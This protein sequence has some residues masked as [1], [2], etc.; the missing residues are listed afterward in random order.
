MDERG[1]LPDQAAP[2]QDS[3][4]PT[5]R[6]ALGSTLLGGLLV[7][8][9]L[10]AR[11]IFSGGETRP[12]TD[13]L[14]ASATRQAT[15]VVAGNQATV[16]ATSP[17]AAGR[18]PGS[19]S[20]T[21]SGQAGDRLRVARTDGQGVVLRASPREDDWTPRGFMDGDWVTVLERRGADW[22]RVRG[23]NGED[24]WVPARYLGP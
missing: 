8:A 11:V 23:D 12:S 7:A 21:P 13:V 5:D 15:R 2:D 22:A 18:I 17:A 20:P 10:A 16:A 4:R 24:G 14:G 1:P 3:T 19:P 9:V 6:I